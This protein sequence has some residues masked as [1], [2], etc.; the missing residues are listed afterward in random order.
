MNHL[1][2]ALM[3]SL[4]ALVIDPEDTIT[5]EIMALVSIKRK[6]IKHKKFL[7]LFFKHLHAVLHS[8]DDKESV[9]MMESELEQFN[10]ASLSHDTREE[11]TTSG[12][13]NDVFFSIEK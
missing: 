13:K 10:V 9:A 6:I 1:A 12:K 11:K 8:N 7:F 3:S 4:K 5:K 2:A